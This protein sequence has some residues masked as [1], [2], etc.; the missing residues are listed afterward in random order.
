MLPKSEVG[1]DEGRQSG[2]WRVD[3][4]GLVGR[5]R[6]G[7]RWGKWLRASCRWRA[8]RED[9]AARTA[10]V[11]SQ[12]QGHSRRPR[13]CCPISHPPLLGSEAMQPQP[14]A[15]NL[16]GI[17]FYLRTAHPLANAHARRWRP[18]FIC[19]SVLLRQRPPARA[20][21]SKCVDKVGR[22]GHIYSLFC[23]IVNPR[24][25]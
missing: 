20:A 16:R 3:G 9:N 7:G 24:T 21:L 18:Q 4:R 5:Y 22:P 14:L 6:G 12:C 10:L 13:Q 11:H 8:S 2:R 17:G 1:R 23:S 25:C 19:N 15:Q